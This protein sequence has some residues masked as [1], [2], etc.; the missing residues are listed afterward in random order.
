MEVLENRIASEFVKLDLQ[1]LIRLWDDMKSL[2]Q[3]RPKLPKIGR[4]EEDHLCR[5]PYFRKSSML[6]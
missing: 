5:V 2:A 1:N 3:T 4:H 6:R